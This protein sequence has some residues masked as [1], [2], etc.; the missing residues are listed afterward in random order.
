MFK[1]SPLHLFA[2]IICIALVV[3]AAAVDWPNIGLRWSIAPHFSTYYNLHDQL[4]E[5]DSRTDPT[6]SY[7]GGQICLTSL[8]R[9][10]QYLEGGIQVKGLYV[11]ETMSGLGSNLLYGET[12]V[13]GRVNYPV[14]GP[15]LASAE[16]GAG[17]WFY[18]TYLQ[19]R[20]DRNRFGLEWKAGPACR[21]FKNG[22]AHLTVGWETLYARLADYSTMSSALDNWNI[23]ISFSIYP[24][25]NGQF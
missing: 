5:Y 19:D 8:Y 20:V 18:Y 2:C 24:F 16:V 1:E 4:S 21:V 13:I 15:W 7:A 25:K 22:T 3:P 11:R 12:G 14:Y 10:G 23:G 17:Y 9:S 6:V